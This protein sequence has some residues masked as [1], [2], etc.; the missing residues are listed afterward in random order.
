[1][2]KILAFLILIFLILSIGYSQ[3]LKILTFDEAVNI[4]QKN[5]KDIL[6]AKINLDNAVFDYENKKKDPT[7]LILALKQAE[8]NVK[9]EQ[10]KYNNTKI[11]VIQSVRN[12]Y[13]SVLEA[14]A[15]VKL[16]EKQVEYY[17]ENL[18]AA[19]LKFQLGNATLTDVKQAEIN[20]LSA[21]NTLKSA[22]NNLSIAWSQFWQTLGVSPMEN[23]TLK[24]PDLVVFNF[25]LDDL[26]NLAKEN[27]TS[28]V[29][30]SN[31]VELYDLQVKLY[32]NEYTPKATLL[33]SQNSLESAKMN[34]EQ[35]LNSAKLTIV[36]RL[37][38]LNAS[39][40]DIELQKS[41]LDLAKENYNITKTRFEAGLI[42]KLDLMN[43]EI[44]LI[45]AENNYYSSL[46]T[47]FKN[48]DNLSISVG[49]A[50]SEGGEVKK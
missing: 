15:Q 39:L 5:N 19:K 47:Y 4:A 34:L 50:L 1:M 44:N 43:A 46:H 26:F 16:Y 45:K 30:A 28:I 13:F 17:L 33:S 31:N 48:L 3:E 6:V 22:E 23:I 37:D 11:Q 38:Q 49:K 12:A 36:Q 10:V 27:L 35:V 42:T 25:T 2:R 24:E 14:Q 7:T 18:N 41:N 32:N 20:Y 40:K 8:L 9:L 29:Q 21:Q